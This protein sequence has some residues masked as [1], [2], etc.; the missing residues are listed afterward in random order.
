VKIVVKREIGK[1][2]ADILNV[3]TICNTIHT[4]GTKDNFGCLT[5]NGMEHKELTV[6]GKCFCAVFHRYVILSFL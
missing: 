6:N 1:K 3:Y 4:I 2:T 5:G